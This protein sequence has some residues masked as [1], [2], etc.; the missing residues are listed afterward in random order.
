MIRDGWIP[1]IYHEFQ[2]QLDLIKK[3]KV[4]EIEPKSPQYIQRAKLKINKKPRL[5]CK[6]TFVSFFRPK[7]WHSF[8][9][10]SYSLVIRKVKT[11][12]TTIRIRTWSMLFAKN[13]WCLLEKEVGHRRWLLFTI[14]A[15]ITLDDL[16]ILHTKKNKN[17]R[18]LHTIRF[19]ISTEIL[20]TRQ[21]T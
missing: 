10:L 17:K 5:V 18:A 11:I 20:P 8:R 19:G 13:F 9:W 21:V 4:R 15:T 1:S 6:E 12:M 16:P 7:G 3:D 2:S 14:V